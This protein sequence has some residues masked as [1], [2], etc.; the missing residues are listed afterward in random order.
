MS[1]EWKVGDRVRLRGA[2][3]DI[4]AGPD[5]IGRFCV[6][7]RSDRIELVMAQDLKPSKTDAE[8]QREQAVYT[9]NNETSGPVCYKKACGE[10]YDAGYRKG[11][12]TKQVKPLSLEEFKEIDYRGS[13]QKVYDTLIEKGHIIGVKDE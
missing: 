4:M 5:R 11:D 10:L 9:M 1:K 2:Q 13:F 6:W 12:L 7:H 8:I 3:V